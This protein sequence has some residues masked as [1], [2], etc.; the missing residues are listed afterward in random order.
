MPKSKSGTAFFDE[1]AAPL[2][3]KHGSDNDDG[4]RLPQQCFPILR[5]PAGAGDSVNSLLEEGYPSPAL[6]LFAGNLELSRR[7]L[8]AHIWSRFA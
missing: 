2:L 4:I 3:T 7:F 1:K 6:L 5:F 8:R